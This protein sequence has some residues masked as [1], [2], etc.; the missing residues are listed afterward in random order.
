MP[1]LFERQ[2]NELYQ[3]IYNS[4]TPVRSSRVDLLKW[5]VNRRIEYHAKNNS[6]RIGNEHGDSVVTILAEMYGNRIY[7]HPKKDEYRANLLIDLDSLTATDDVKIV[8]NN[9][10]ATG[11]AVVTIAEYEVE[12]RHH[13]D[14]KK[15]NNRI[16]WLTI[17]LVLVGILQVPYVQE[18]LGI[19][20]Q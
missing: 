16:F 6:Y 14:N 5:L 3:A 12:N 9:Y 17:V 1:A 19:R 7:S 11:R 2:K 4:L 20:A 18:Y 8:D 13:L 10:V 15:H